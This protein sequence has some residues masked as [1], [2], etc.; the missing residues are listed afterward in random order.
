MILL[1]P[2]SKTI[3]LTLSLVHYLELEATL[4]S[5]FQIRNKVHALKYLI[6]RPTS[7]IT[8]LLSLTLRPGKL[9]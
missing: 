9:L 7:A 5:W 8:L 2:F 3:S 4:T 6:L 1:Q